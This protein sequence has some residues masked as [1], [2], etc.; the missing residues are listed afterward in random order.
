MKNI[1]PNFSLSIQI[2]L[3][4]GALLG[5]FFVLQSVWVIATIPFV[6]IIYWLYRD[7]RLLI[8]IAFL[9]SMIGFGYY[10]N[11]IIANYNQTQVNIPQKLEN[12]SII[13]ES[14]VKVQKFGYQYKVYIPEY[15]ARAF[16]TIDNQNLE[17][18]N[19]LEI[20]AKTS[21]PEER[22]IRRFLL[23]RNI[24]IYMTVSKYQTLDS[25][26]C[27]LQCQVIKSITSLRSIILARIDSAYPNQVGEFLKGILIGYTD[28]LP[29][30]I[31]EFFKK[32]GVSHILAVS[33]YNWLLL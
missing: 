28:T 13:I 26:Q 4:I 16:M 17:Y 23:G 14:N 21:I 19:Q 30:D 7:I 12:A 18:G 20:N 24:H 33:G 22:G 11:H 3:L 25:I 9:V 32:T 15:Q 31:K 5:S 27:N 10:I 29:N 1:I 8:L 2:G 6:I